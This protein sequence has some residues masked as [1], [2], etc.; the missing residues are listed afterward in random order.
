ME[1]A[2]ASLSQI[3]HLGRWKSSALLIYMRGGKQLASMPGQQFQGQLSLRVALQNRMSSAKALLLVA[4]C[5]FCC[6]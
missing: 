5:S 6:Q 3:K 2:G 4:L 1:A